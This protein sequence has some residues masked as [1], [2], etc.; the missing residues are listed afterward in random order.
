MSAKNRYEK[1]VPREITRLT[2]LLN[3]ISDFKK[4]SSYNESI[5][6][7]EFEKLKKELNGQNKTS[8]KLKV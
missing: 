5:D 1:D 6:M 8:T 3:K 4:Q 2:S 7:V